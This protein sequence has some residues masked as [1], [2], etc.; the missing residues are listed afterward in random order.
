MS[1]YKASVATC[2]WCRRA[3][4]AQLALVV[5]ERPCFWPTQPILPLYLADN[6]SNVD[7]VSIVGLVQ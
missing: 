6:Y 7:I 5:L 4:V 2:Q 3:R 1:S